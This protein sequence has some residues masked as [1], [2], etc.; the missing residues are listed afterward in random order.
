MC[1]FLKKIGLD[2]QYKNVLEGKQAIL[3]YKL[4]ILKKSKIFHF[5]KGVNPP[6]WSKIWNFFQ[7]WFSKE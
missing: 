1:G 4:V 2:I 3:D 6:F 5:S 7:L